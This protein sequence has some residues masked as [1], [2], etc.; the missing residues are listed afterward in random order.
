M[1]ENYAANP[2]SWRTFLSSRVGERVC[3]SCSVQGFGRVIW[4]KYGHDTKL[5]QPSTLKERWLGYLLWRRWRRSAEEFLRFTDASIRLTI[6]GT[7]P[8]CVR[9]MTQLP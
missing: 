5:T 4:L 8:G 7:R 1:A 6:C 2:I 9:S 3:A